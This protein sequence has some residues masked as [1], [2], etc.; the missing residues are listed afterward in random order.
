ME[1]LDPAPGTEVQSTLDRAMCGQLGEIRRGPARADDVVRA[2]GGVTRPDL[3]VGDQV[4]T[5]LPGLKV[6]RGGDPAVLDGHQACGGQLLHRQARRCPS[7][8]HGDAEP[9]QPDQ[10]AERVTL[11]G[12]AQGGHRL[13]AR[14]RGGGDVTESLADAVD[15]VAGVEQKLSEPVQQIVHRVILAPGTSGRPG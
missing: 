13:L 6:D 3:A 1:N 4:T 2:Q 12:G 9:P 5:G 8:L 15:G 7:R 10:D 14:E 11:A